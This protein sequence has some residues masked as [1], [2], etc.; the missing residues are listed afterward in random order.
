MSFDPN[1]H[2]KIQGG[3]Q[4]K[5]QP[6]KIRQ[7]SKGAF[8]RRLTL[9]EKVAIQ[10]S[11]DPVVKVLDDDLKASSFVDLDYQLLIDGLNYLESIGI[12]TSARVTELLADGTED[13]QV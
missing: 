6:A 4:L 9:S 1:I 8:R 10:T 5:S 2:E 12:L 13:E 7:I 11:T 3:Y